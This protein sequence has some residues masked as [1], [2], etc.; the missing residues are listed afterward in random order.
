MPN[1]R[2]AAG[3]PQ[4][5]ALSRWNRRQTDDWITSTSLPD[6]HRLEQE[7]ETTSILISKIGAAALTGGSAHFGLVVSYHQ[8]EECNHGAT[9]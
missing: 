4:S 1:T 6:R 3:L 9:P 7:Q 2:A 5:S 8:L